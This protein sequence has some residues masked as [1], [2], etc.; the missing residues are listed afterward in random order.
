M[1][2]V[3]EAVNLNRSLMYVNQHQKCVIS[4]HE[5]EIKDLSGQLLETR[6]LLQSKP[7]MSSQVQTQQTVNTLQ[8]QLHSVSFDRTESKCIRS[9]K[10]ILPVSFILFTFYTSPGK[11]FKEAMP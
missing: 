2:T 8:Q 6:V 7:C 5:R 11:M 1:L 3:K 4:Q 9:L 10:N